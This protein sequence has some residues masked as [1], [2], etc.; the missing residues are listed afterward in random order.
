VRQLLA[1]T[2]STA[3]PRLHPDGCVVGFGGRAAASR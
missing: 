2:A 1:M 3:K